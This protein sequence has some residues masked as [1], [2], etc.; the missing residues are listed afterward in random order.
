MTLVGLDLGHDTVLAA[1][2]WIHD[3]V[4]RLGRPAG[5][6]ACTHMASAPR[7]HV[8]V[9]LSSPVAGLADG[10]TAVDLDPEGGRAVFYPGV[11]TLVGR[12]TVGHI[13]AST[14]I[15]RI[16]VLGGGDPSDDQVVETRDFV[17]PLWSGGVLT[18]TTQPAWDGLL[19][20]FETPNPTPCCADHR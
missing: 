1:E 5:L 15:D 20:P 9:S 3:L 13:L 19:V 11:D 18:L 6:V 16:V 7:P 10:G 17:R 2:H 4:D 8:V 12:V 14:A